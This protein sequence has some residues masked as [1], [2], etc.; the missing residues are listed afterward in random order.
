MII[1]RIKTIKEIKNIYDK[2]ETFSLNACQKCMIF[3]NSNKKI[4][5]IVKHNN[6]QK[7]QRKY[8]F[9]FN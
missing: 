9:L 6:Y 3:F 4:T 1:I 2:S 5:G 7:F 8:D